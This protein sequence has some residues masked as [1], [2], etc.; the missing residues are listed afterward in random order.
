[1]A[2]QK[3]E[4]HACGASIADEREVAQTLQCAGR[5]SHLMSRRGSR[6]RRLGARP[7]KLGALEGRRPWP[8]P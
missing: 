6:A 5:G 2:D 7:V 4:R 1:M 8:N 3:F